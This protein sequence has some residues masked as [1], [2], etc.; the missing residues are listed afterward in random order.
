M[1]GRP[2][3]ENRA[4]SQAELVQRPLAQALIESPAKGFKLL[5]KSTDPGA[6]RHG[7]HQSA[8]ALPRDHPK[9]SRPSWPGKLTTPSRGQ[10]NVDWAPGG[11][12]ENAPTRI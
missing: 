7:L 4:A 3:R 2:P 5:A 1:P 12:K 11:Q 8:D 9:Q 10:A 6:E